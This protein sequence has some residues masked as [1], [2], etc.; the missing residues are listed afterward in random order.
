VLLFTLPSNIPHISDGLRARNILLQDPM[1]PYNPALHS[2]HPKYINAHRA[3]HE[4]IA[5][6]QALQMAQLR[7]SGYGQPSMDRQQ[8]GDMQKKQVEAVFESLEQ[9]AEL[10]MCDPGEMRNELG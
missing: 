9:A 7:A 2:E 6:Q 8:I 3:I 10:E 4:I 1:I 5:R